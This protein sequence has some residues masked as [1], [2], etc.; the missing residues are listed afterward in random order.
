MIRNYLKI[1]LRNLMKYKFI[2]FINL[3]GLTVGL[4]CC[5]L[6]LTYI[7]HEISYDRFH[8]HADRTYRVTRVFNNPE[9][10]SVSLTL[11]T[12][13]PAFG[14]LLRN[15]FPEI[16]SMT[17]TLNNG[18]AAIRY[19]EKMFNE[20]NTYFAD[21]RFFDFFKMDLTKGNPAKSLADPYSVVMSEE[22]AKKYFGNEEPLNKVI[23][24]NLGNYFDFKVT[25]VFK[26]LPSNTHF[27]PEMMMSFSTLNDSVIYGAQNLRTNFGN[28]SFFTY[29]RLP[30]HY[31]PKRLESQFPAFVDRNMPRD[32]GGPYKPSQ[33]TRLG[34]QKLTDIHL[35]SHTDYEAEENGDIRRVYIFSAIALFIL[36][37]ACINYMNLSTARSTLRAREIGIRKVSGAQRKEI[38]FQ[39]LS[40]SIL[41][42]WVSMLMAFLFTWLLMP[43]LNKLSGQ[44]LD[45]GVLFQWKVFIPILLAPFVV[46]ILSGIYPAVFMSS[47]QPVK[48]L[49]GLLK[50]GG[51]ARFRK[52]LVGVQ[53]AISIILLICTAIVSDQMRY[54]QSKSLGFDRNH[55]INL[56]YTTALNDTY[57]AFRNELLT[58]SNIKNVGRSSRIPTG[59]LLDAMGAR[60]ASGDT[61]VPVTA[62]IKFVSADQDFVSTYGLKMV[63]GRDF[64]RDFSTDTS[65]FL[66]NEAAAKVLGFKSSAD[67]I[68]ANFGYGNRRGKLIGVFNDFHFESMHEKI[69]PL[70]LL[71][72]RNANNYGNISIKA[73]GANMSSTMAFIEKTWKKVL[74]ETPYQSAFLDES[75]ARLYQAEERQGTLFMIFACLAI[76]IACLG[77]F[78]LSAF[79]ISQR[80]KEIGIRKILG[81]KIS[82]IVGLLSR[83]FLKLVGLAAIISFPVAY[84]AM[85]KWLQD[86]AYRISIP[87]WVFLFAAAVAAIIAFITISF[88]AV[89]A[90]SAN[91]VKN[92]RTE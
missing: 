56:P 41:I 76:F 54:M 67:V 8:P 70:V 58:N 46:G 43:A 73:S 89:R 29:I 48:V 60:M 80:I 36:L 44:Q 5:L 30:Q 64:S 75:F 13:A 23:R 1:A 59:R 91:P 18:T 87:W 42:A 77:L 15:D 86:F 7:L 25:G 10:G 16:E 27:H 14:P 68:G 9:T 82:S 4:T 45:P 69:V 61:L 35:R 28:N 22:M 37:I 6:I 81:A 88:Q 17:R 79:T 72:P 24:I 11:S 78:G 85:Y 12:I 74:P 92:L 21:D 31:D 2:S 84:Y 90:A 20:Q 34:L 50:I 55:I 33:G 66:I 26:P 51:G 32:G 53:F 62:N 65:A 52:A 38:M 83:D 3:F 57:D 71:V 63:A 40:E 19:E 39:F 47:F 49:K